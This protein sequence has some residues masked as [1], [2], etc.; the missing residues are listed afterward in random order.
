MEQLLRSLLLTD[1]GV[2]AKLGARIWWGAVPQGEAKVPN[3]AVLQ[4]IDNNPDYHMQGKSSY[5]LSRVQ[6][7]VYSDDYKLAKDSVKS[8]YAKLSGFRDDTFQGIF[9]DT[10]R[11]MPV[12]DPGQVTNLFRVSVDFMVHYRSA[13]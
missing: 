3:Y 10:E 2:I 12:S 1:P 8:I 5:A 13:N 9:V 6:L 7:D 4:M 11:D